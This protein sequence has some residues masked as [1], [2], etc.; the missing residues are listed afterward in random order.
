MIEKCTL[1]F[2][3]LINVPMNAIFVFEECA[4]FGLITESMFFFAGSVSPVKELSSIV[5]S[6]AS[7]KRISAGTLSPTFK[8]TI[9]PGTNSLAKKVSADPSL[10]L[11]KFQSIINN[12]SDELNEK[13]R[14][15]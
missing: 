5:R 15:S 13:F 6:L 14:C 12:F 1:P 9:S 7:I 2:P 11:E 8:S 3:H 10:V 4:P